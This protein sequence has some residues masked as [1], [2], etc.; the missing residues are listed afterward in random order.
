MQKTITILILLT[1]GCCA[2]AQ[3]P[4]FVIN[5]QAQGTTYSIQYYAER[6]L[7]K[8]TSIDSILKEIDQSMSLYIDSSLI[9]KVNRSDTS[10]VTLDRQMLTV[11]K[12]AFCVNHISQGL[13]DVT[14]E[15][16][17]N[18][19]GFGQRPVAH[20]PEQFMLDSVLEFVGMNQLLLEGNKLKKKD[21]RVRIDLNGI[22]Q[23]YTVDE[24]AFFFNQNHVSNYIIELGGEIRAKGH[25]GEQQLFE[26]AI[27]RPPGLEEGKFVLQLT[28]RAVTT[29]GN[30]RRGFDLNG[31]SIH[32]HI[33]PFSGYPVQ[34][35]VASVTVIANT[36][37]D[38]DAYDNVF[39]A[40]SA[41]Q[42]VQLANSMENMDVYIIYKDK[43]GFKELFSNNFYRY[44]KK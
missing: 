11:L 6:E 29:S 42:G 28:D 37:M 34:N 10:G 18:L 8:R 5:G 39:M 33:D 24:L 2:Y 12:K 3:Q 40:L 22:A 25:K 7:I 9:S 16:L 27:E 13:F 21:A 20:L 31:R 19:W 30:Y 23:G 4:K 41:E 14:V 32:H 15:P 38:A 44:I 17:V 26:I 43:E 1:L 35:N 36:A